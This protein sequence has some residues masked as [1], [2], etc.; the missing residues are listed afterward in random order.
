MWWREDK[1]KTVR[2]QKGQ[3]LWFTLMV[4]I[5]GALVIA[6]L[7]AYL[8]TSLLVSARSQENTYA[9]YAANAGV[10]R[11]IA[12]LLQGVEAEDNSYSVTLNGYSATVEVGDDWTSFIDIEGTYEDY[13]IVST[14]T[15]ADANPVATITCYAR[16]MPD[17]VEDP[18]GPW[19]VTILSWQIE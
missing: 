1:T 6:G 15:D 19:T 8:S 18:D 4:M 14:V 12:D 7:F 11:V 2:D 13:K 10:E 5:F 17:P 9:Y 16:Q 3:V